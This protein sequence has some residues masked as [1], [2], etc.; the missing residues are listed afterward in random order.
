MRD[1]Y[2]L[3]EVTFK[4]TKYRNDSAFKHP[5][6]KSGL[7]YKRWEVSAL[8]IDK[9]YV[10]GES[11]PDDKFISGDT[12]TF[13]EWRKESED[14]D[15]KGFLVTLIEN[16]EELAKTAT[17]IGEHY[18]DLMYFCGTYGND[19]N[20]NI[21]NDNIIDSIEK[22]GKMYKLPTLNILP[23]RKAQ[24]RYYFQCYL[25]YSNCKLIMHLFDIKNWNNVLGGDYE[26]FKG[27]NY[28]I[29]IDT[30]S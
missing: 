11:H 16:F 14:F 17:G 12:V 9:D 15:P 1:D 6:E 13:T 7:K 28:K 29:I 23:F 27:N 5:S 25:L 2:I 24:D 3:H 26:Y 20:S 21:C 10:E 19:M 8:M 18:R 4:P 30:E 22:F